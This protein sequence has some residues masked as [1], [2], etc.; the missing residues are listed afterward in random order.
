MP[1]PKDFIVP[2]KLPIDQL[3]EIPPIPDQLFGIPTDV[4]E[5]VGGFHALA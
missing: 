3:G 2:T 4:I 5:L 1:D